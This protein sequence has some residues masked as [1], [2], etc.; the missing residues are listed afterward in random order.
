MDIFLL[1][2]NTNVSKKVI[3]RL[4]ELNHSVD[5]IF[6]FM[7]FAIGHLSLTERKVG[8][9]KQGCYYKFLNIYGVKG[10]KYTLQK[11]PY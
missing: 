9:Y 11:Y 7:A 8:N 3:Y 1:Y 10:H 5:L 4:N 6:F 2:L